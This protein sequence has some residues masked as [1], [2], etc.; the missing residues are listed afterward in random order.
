MATCSWRDRA[1]RS[2]RARPSSTR[3]ISSPTVRLPVSGCYYESSSKKNLP[4]RPGCSET[5][6]RP[7]TSALSAL[8]ALL[9]CARLFFYLTGSGVAMRTWGTAVLAGAGAGAGV[10]QLCTRPDTRPRHVLGGRGA[11]LAG[12]G[13]GHEQ[14]GDPGLCSV[15]PRSH[16]G[17]PGS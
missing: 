15:R 16:P 6:T 13:G 1:S 2:T 7:D 10:A 4:G 11:T 14:A 5:G 9:L 12:S 3:N 17:P 8:S